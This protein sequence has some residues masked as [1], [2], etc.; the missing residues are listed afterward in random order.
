L[1]V[2]FLIIALFFAL[3]FAG[4]GPVSF[5][6][7][8]KTSG[9]KIVG[10]KTNGAPVQV[11]GVSFGW[12]YADWESGR[13][14]TEVAVDRMVQDWDAEVIRA[15]YGATPYD[16]YSETAAQNR[17]S[18]ETVVEQAFANDVYVIID[19]HSHNAHNEVENAK[20]FFEYMAEKYGNY[21]NVI[22]E[23][24]NEP[25]S[26]NNGTW[27]NIKA[28]AEIIIPVIRKYS[29]NLVLVGTPQ[30]CQRV[31]KVIGNAINDENV[32]YV[33]HFYAYSH[34]LSSFKK[35]LNSVLDAG[36]SVFVSE[37]GTVQSDGGDP[38]KNHYDTHD[39][40]KAEEWHAYM[41]EKKISSAAWSINDKEEGSAF[42]GIP[43]AAKKFD[44]NG[45]W[46]DESK[47]TESG[48]YIFK[49]L[50]KYA[51]T[52]PWR[53]GYTPIKNSAISQNFEQANAVVY[54]LSGKKIGN[55]SE[56]S[57]QNGVYMLISRQNGAVQ[58]KVLKIVK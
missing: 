58:K 43:G 25:V 36:F 20:I 27:E 39:V 1:A 47:M 10:S 56:V 5:Y 6:G 53:P 31:D 48:K 19:W 54:S 28:Y 24:Y 44:M 52:A 26:A 40:V 51:E 33:F 7:E 34:P 12:S 23:I 3:S 42:F 45:S 38:A 13:F 46:T 15:A 49:R 41:D 37:Y 18:I 11:R 16:F 50:K 30:W 9:N 32:A 55:F 57:L 29:A 14:Y 4:K 35:Y 22:F 17:A 8:L 2:N 21:E